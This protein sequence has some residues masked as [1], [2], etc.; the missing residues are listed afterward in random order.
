[1]VLRTIGRMIW[2]PLSFLIAAALA[3][4]VLVTLGLETITHAV[5]NLDEAD[6]ISAAFDVVWQ[7]SLSSRPGRRSFPR[8]WSSSSARSRASA[9]G[10]T[11]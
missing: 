6:T 7:G 2:M 5:H 8:C 9:R 4:F 11:T 10:S 3:M 1:M